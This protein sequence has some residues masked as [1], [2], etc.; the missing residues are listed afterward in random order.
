[1]IEFAINN[2][3]HTST[4]HTPLH[5]NS[6]RHPRSHQ[7]FDGGELAEANTLLA[8]AYLAK[9]LRSMRSI[10]MLILLPL[11]KDRARHNNIAISDFDNDTERLSIESKDTS[12]SNNDAIK[13]NLT[14][15]QRALVT[16][17]RQNK[18]EPA[19]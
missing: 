5:V 19:M 16:L 11:K 4:K 2:S 18:T 8:L 1:M 10:P 7:I 3:L 17:K 14:S 13:E 12:E 6:L 15:P 9:T